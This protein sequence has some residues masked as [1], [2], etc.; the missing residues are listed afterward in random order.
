MPLNRW[1][2]YCTH[3]ASHPHSAL[4]SKIAKYGV[5]QK[6]TELFKPVLDA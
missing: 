4:S 3:S 2:S 1:I 5:F 6:F